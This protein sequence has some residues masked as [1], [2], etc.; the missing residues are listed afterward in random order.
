MVRYQVTIY[1]DIVNDKLKSKGRY[2]SAYIEELIKKDLNQAEQDIVKLIKQLI[3]E[4][5]NG[6]HIVMG[7]K[8][9]EEFNDDIMSRIATSVQ[10]VM[11]IS[12]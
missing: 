1:D 12:K 10:G 7:S 6:Q 3:A 11:G 9:E 8:A 5:L 4:Q 2:K